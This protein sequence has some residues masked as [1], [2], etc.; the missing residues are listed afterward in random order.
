MQVRLARADEVDE[1]GW[2]TLAAY[3]HNGY[4]VEDDFYAAHLLDAEARRTGG[5]LYVAEFEGRVV[6]TVTDCP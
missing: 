3:T 5:E 4:L 6:G 2:L 1:V